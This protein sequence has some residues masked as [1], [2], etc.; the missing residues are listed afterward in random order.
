MAGVLLPYYSVYDQLIATVGLDYGHAGQST[1]E[2]SAA[3]SPYGAT[4]ISGRDGSR[5]PT[6]NELE[7]ARLQ[8]RRI[9][10]ITKKV[11]R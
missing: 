5:K 2:E 10:E 6:R 11:H 7:S 1:V 9:A 4:T 3:G 8:G